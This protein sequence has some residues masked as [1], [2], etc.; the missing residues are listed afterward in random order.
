[1]DNIKQTTY[2]KIQK[3]NNVSCSWIDVQKSYNDL[4]TAISKLTNDGKSRIMEV[5]GKVRKPLTL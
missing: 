3:Y 4:N 2:Y 5:C 1:M